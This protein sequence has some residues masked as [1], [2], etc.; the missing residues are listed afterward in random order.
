VLS[1]A[2]ELDDTIELS[3]V[4]CTLT[5]R[6]IHADVQFPGADEEADS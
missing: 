1:A 5:L 4:G 2:T 6:E 3:S